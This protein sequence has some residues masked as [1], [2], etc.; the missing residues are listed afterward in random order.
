LSVQTCDPTVGSKIPDTLFD[1][2]LAVM[3]TFNQHLQ[4]TPWHGDESLMTDASMTAV[5]AYQPW[6]TAGQSASTLDHIATVRSPQ[7]HWSRPETNTKTYLTPTGSMDPPAPSRKKKAP[8]L[9]ASDWEPYK[10]R[11]IELHIV[12]NLS[13]PN[14][15][16]IIEEEFGFKAE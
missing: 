9:R 7:T 6:T 4:Q 5:D 11:I 13:I 8:T 14:V 16:S 10:A 15:R 2:S 12:Q 3:D 1:I